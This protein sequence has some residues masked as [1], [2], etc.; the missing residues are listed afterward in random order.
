VRA[1]LEEVLQVDLQ[2]DLEVVLQAA[3]YFDGSR[4]LS[5]HSFHSQRD[6]ISCACHSTLPAAFVPISATYSL[7]TDHLCRRSFLFSPASK[8]TKITRSVIWIYFIVND[9]LRSAFRA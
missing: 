1:D 4:F 6:R 3:P 5:Q 8:R 9:D 7:A 2:A